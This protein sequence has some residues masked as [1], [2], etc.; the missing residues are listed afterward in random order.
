MI[1]KKHSAKNSFRK[2]SAN[3]G[4]HSS[5][6]MGKAKNVVNIVTAHPRHSMP[7]QMNDTNQANE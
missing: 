7:T 1:R 4:L 6:G 5:T 3:N 2:H